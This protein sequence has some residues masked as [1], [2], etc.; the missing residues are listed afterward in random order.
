AGGGGFTEHAE[1]RYWVVRQCHET[2]HPGAQLLAAP[3][4]SWA[5]LGRT[6]EH[7]SSPF[8]RATER[9]R[10]AEQQGVGAID[11][12][13][14]RL[15]SP[16]GSRAAAV[17]GPR[18]G[19]WDPLGRHLRRGPGQQRG[20]GAA[21]SHLPWRADGEDGP[22]PDHAEAV[23]YRGELPRQRGDHDLGL[24]DP[25]PR[26]GHQRKRSGKRQRTK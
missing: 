15:A 14:E 13:G 8:N 10:A 19:R 23:R 5:R 25:S 20:P 16:Y 22:R 1:E 12:P 3:L 26:P 11:P 21:R 24:P 7:A 17:A 4:V 2:P 18:V 6:D 9:D